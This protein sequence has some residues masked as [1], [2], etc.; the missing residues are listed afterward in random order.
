[1]IGLATPDGNDYFQSIVVIQGGFVEL[2]A[3]DDFAIALNSD[4]FPHQPKLIH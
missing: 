2:A 4:T 3:R 1:M